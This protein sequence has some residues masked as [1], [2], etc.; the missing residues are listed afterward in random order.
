MNFNNN[1]TKWLI[2]ALVFMNIFLLFTF[3][4]SRPV[5]HHRHGSKEGHHEKKGL[6][7]LKNELDLSE[8][9][10]AKFKELR[11]EHFLKKKENYKSIRALRKEMIDAITADPQDADKA[12]SIANQIG[13][14]E[15]EK[16]LKLVDHY[17][18]LQS[19]CTPEQR[20]KL[21]S[22]FKEAMQRHKKSRKKRHE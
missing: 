5:H 10:V 15:I 8:N 21:A 20:E 16:E 18:K 13:Q 11:L 4:T 19:E 9:Q 22:V 14:I 12:K 6:T 3:F 17:L 2:G 7:F 1:I